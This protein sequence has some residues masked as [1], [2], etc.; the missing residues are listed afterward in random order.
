MSFNAQST[1]K[2]AVL[3]FGAGTQPKPAAAPKKAKEA[4]KEE[5]SAKA[6]PDDGEGKVIENLI[7]SALS[8]DGMD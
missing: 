5:K 3:E 4:K 8:L 6:T 2:F 1:S 7:L